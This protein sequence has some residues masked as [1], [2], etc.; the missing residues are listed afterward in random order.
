MSSPEVRLFAGGITRLQPEG[1]P[2]G[3]Y[4]HAL[5]GPVW[6]GR[7]GLAGDVQADRRVHGG[8]DKALHHYAAENYARLAAAFPAIAG[9]LLPGSLGENLSTRGWSEAQVCVGDVFRLGAARLQVSQPR[10]PCWKIESK[11]ATS[12]LSRH[13]A[14]H[15]LTGWYYR[16]LEPGRVAAGDDFERIEQAPGALTLASLWR[17]SREH[18]PDLDALAAAARAPGLAPEWARRLAER[19][20]WLRR[21]PEGGR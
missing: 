1:E 5:A 19:L 13:I 10:S 12:G 18:R 14:E 9:A 17:L 4:K 16:V 11:F 21:H 6:L 3:I 15:G 20:D 8:P 2:S 7:E